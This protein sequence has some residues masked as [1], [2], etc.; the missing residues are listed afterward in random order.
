M[1]PDETENEEYYILNK[2]VTRLGPFTIKELKKQKLDPTTP[3][4]KKGQNNWQYAATLK[5]LNKKP[6]NLTIERIALFLFT[7]II[8]L[9]ILIFTV[10][11]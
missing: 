11:Q 1:K 5:P 10:I 7:S 8:I 3:L 6:L 4:L 9:L 2:G